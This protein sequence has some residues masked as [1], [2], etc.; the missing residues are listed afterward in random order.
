MRKSITVVSIIAVGIVL[1]AIWIGTSLYSRIPE[2]PAAALKSF[3]EREVAED[4]LM[5]PLILAGSGVIPLLEQDLL[6]S[7]MPRR[8]YAIGAVGNIGDNAA[9]P[10]LKKIV[11]DR[12]E[13]DY[14]RCDALEAVAMIDRS[15]AIQ[16]VRDEPS[17]E[18]QCGTAALSGAKSRNYLEALLGWHY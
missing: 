1:A 12:S 14:I 7:D 17:L 11:E 13:V 15:V 10:T 3:Y 18:P 2:S 6:D 4:Q 16:I 8:R 5:D 9:L